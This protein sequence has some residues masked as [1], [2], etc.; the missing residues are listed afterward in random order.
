V[1]DFRFFSLVSNQAFQSLLLGFPVLMCTP[2]PGQRQ[3]TSDFSVASENPREGGL[4]GSRG[5]LIKLDTESLQSMAHLVY[6]APE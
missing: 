2:K 5:Y 4:A 1:C 3:L 6:G